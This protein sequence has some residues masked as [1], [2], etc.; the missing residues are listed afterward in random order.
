MM[1]KAWFSIEEVPYYFSGD[2]LNLEVTRAEKSMIRIQ[3]E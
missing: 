3:F 2:P 1:H